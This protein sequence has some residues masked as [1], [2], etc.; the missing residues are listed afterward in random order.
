MLQMTRRGFVRLG[1]S[2]AVLAAT[3][4]SPAGCGEVARNG[5]SPV[6]LIIEAL[7]ADS[8]ADNADQFATLLMSDVET[9]VGVQVGNETVR[10]P[11]RFNDL[12]RV[13][14]RLALKNPG[15]PTSPLEPTTLNEMTVTRYRVVFRRTD[16]R[17]TQGVD[18]PYAFEGGMTVT[19][20]AQGTVEGIFD[21]VRHTAKSE[22]PLKNLSGEGAG[23]FINTVADIT[24]FGRDQAGSEAS[25]SGLISVNFAD[26]GDPQ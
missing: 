8:G 22:P 24:F 14:L 2:A 20:P 10:V 1:L 19:V 6:F 26:F 18:V 4:L 23:R 25:V 15:L 3:A 13:R 16:G 9:V 7:E 17:N 5:H 12:G 11:T 21:V